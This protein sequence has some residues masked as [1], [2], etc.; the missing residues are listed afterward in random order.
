MDEL[1]WRSRLDAGENVEVHALLVAATEADGAAPVSEHV[2]LH[3]RHGGDVAS[4]HLLVRTGDELAGYAH[5]DLSDRVAGGAAELVVAVEHRRRGLGSRI[6][7]ALLDRSGPA[8]LRLWA[9]GEHPAALRLAERYGFRRARVLWQMRR[10][11][12]APLP[13]VPLP[14]GLRLRTFVPGGDEA[15]VVELN[16]RAFAGHPEQGGWDVEQLRVRE[17]EPW[18]DPAGFFLAVDGADRLHGFHWTKVHGA[19]SGNGAGH[20]HEPI[21]EVYVV[22]VDPDARG[23]GLGTALTVAGLRH[24]RGSGLRQVLLYVDADN[25]GALRL[26]ANLGFIHWETDVS[27]HR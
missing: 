23:V 9:H 3:L 12:R 27:F 20:G 19:D 4:H 2:L 14:D 17:K 24:L 15:A 6:V 22:G 5:L 26:Y 18:F 7:Q 25:A 1:H 16:N 10:N 13:E 21:G 11:L 8:G